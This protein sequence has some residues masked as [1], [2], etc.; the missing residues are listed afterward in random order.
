MAAYVS[1][2]HCGTC[3]NFEWNGEEYSKGYCKWYKTYYYCDDSCEH[4]EDDGEE[5]WN[6]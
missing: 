6:Y 2:E 3:E 4:W 1:K 5:L